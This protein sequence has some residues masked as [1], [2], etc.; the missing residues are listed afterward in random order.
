MK[1]SAGFR[2]VI[3]CIIVLLLMQVMQVKAAGLTEQVFVTLK[4]NGQPIFTDTSPYISR[5][6]TFV[7]VRF[8][9]QAFGMEVE[10]LQEEKKVTIKDVEKTVEMWIGSDRFA[11]N[12]QEYL[13]DV[14]VD[15]INGRAMVPVRFIAEALGFTVA[16]NDYTYSVEM[17]KDGVAIPAASIQNRT[18]TD[19]DIL[20]LSKIVQVEGLNIG[21]EGKVAIAN[22]VLNRKKSDEFPGTVYDVIF[23][24]QYCAQFPPAHKSGFIEL[25][26][27]GSCV[28][29]A[30]MAL[31][32]INNIDS[33]LYFN[34]VPFKGKDNDLFTVIDGEYFYY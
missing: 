6:R 4:I 34:H 21:L 8:I 24:T 15:G 14:P 11:V 33:C 28:I 5:N 18:Y 23:D 27:D 10:W 17:N 7:P 30:K 12:N 22:V 9:A 29:A 13:M 19:D 3:M 25:K 26:P 2:L 16:W 32:G 31:E 1:K 20:W